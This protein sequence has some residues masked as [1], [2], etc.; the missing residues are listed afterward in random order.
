VEIVATE[1]TV[2]Y[3]AG[4]SGRN[5]NTRDDSRGSRRTDEAEEVDER[6]EV[7]DGRGTRD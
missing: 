1:T 3:G 5:T 6:D 4:T 2:S 7:V